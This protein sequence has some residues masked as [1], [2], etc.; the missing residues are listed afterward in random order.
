MPSPVRFAVIGL[1][2]NHIQGMTRALKEAGATLVAV[3]AP[4]DELAKPFLETHP[5]AKRVGDKRQILEDK[6]IHCVL[7][8]SINNE[9]APLGIEVMRHGKDFLV[10][11]PGVTTLEDLAQ[12]RQVQ[13]ETGRKYLIWFSE[14]L[15]QRAT[16]KAGELVK[17]GAIGRVFHTVGL[18]PH[19]LRA[20]TRPAWFFKRAQYGG[21]LTDIASHQLDQF[22]FFTEAT[23]AEIVASHVGN[24]NNPDHPELEDFGDVLVRGKGPAGEATGYVRV[25]WFTPEGLGVWGDG[26]LTLAGTEGTIELRKYVDIAGRTGANHLFLVDNKG[27]NYMDCSATPLPFA[28]QFLVDVIDRTE[29]AMSQEHCFAVCEL[30]LTAQ[31]RAVRL[32]KT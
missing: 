13:R 23:S 8:A 19:H 3:H 24:Q 22:L 31:A 20:A 18:G 26:R 28:Q 5:G 30:A 7:S 9:R 1:N 27:I 2:H 29:T 12:L 16:V 6:S 11:K 4:E 10:D 17:A 32:G 21:V 25:D 14:R 15:E